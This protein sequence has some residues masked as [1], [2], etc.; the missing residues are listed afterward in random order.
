MKII[1]LATGGFD[2]IHDGHIHYLEASKN[3]GDKLYVGLN[4]DKWLERKKGK[5]F[6]PFDVRKK[7]IENLKM[8]D[9]VISFNDNEEDAC[10]AIYQLIKKYDR[11]TFANGGDRTQK[12]SPEYKVYS[13]MPWV[14]FEFGVGGTKINSSSNLL[15]KYEKNEKN[16]LH[17][18]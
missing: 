1:V 2:P 10:D 11:I 12:N 6:M 16:Y 13:R 14:R 9:K 7:V 4:S 3:L 15:K 5:A 8:V 17:F 18:I